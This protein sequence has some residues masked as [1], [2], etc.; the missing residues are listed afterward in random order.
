M[1]GESISPS[2]TWHSNSV[3][4]LLTTHIFDGVNVIPSCMY[5]TGDGII[6]YPN[7]IQKS[8]KSDVRT[9]R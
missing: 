2:A 8:L 7:R 5:V 6:N 4:H 1:H 3:I 9:T